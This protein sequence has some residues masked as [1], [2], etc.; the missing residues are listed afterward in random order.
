MKSMKVSVR[1]QWGTNKDDPKM[2]TTPKMKT[3][4]KMEIDIELKEQKKTR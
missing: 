2:K 3:A 1:S 4:Q